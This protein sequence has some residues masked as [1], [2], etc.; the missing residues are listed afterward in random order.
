MATNHDDENAKP[1]LTVRAALVLLCG[2]LSG[3]GAGTL[4]FL[5]Y[6]SG[7]GAALFGVGAAV[8]GV[9]FFHWLIG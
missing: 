7:F 2:V 1:L 6:H 9:R 3:I 8:T 4:A 5:A